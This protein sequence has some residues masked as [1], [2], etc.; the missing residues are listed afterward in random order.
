MN[1][2]CF[3]LAIAIAIG[4]VGCGSRQEA[5][6]PDKPERGAASA[7]MRQREASALEGDWAMVSLALAG[8]SVNAPGGS[9]SFQGGR[10]IMK[11]PAGETK[12]Y[13]YRMDPL[14]NPKT[15]EM[16]DSQDT[17]AAPKFAI[18]ELE[19]KSLRLCFGREGQRPTSFDAEGTRVFLLHHQ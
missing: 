10:M 16:T 13:L 17:N 12:T 7:D 1:A 14:A 6:T 8:K 19:G 18:Y 2:R 9:I 11:D 4:I 5:S 15:I 3:I